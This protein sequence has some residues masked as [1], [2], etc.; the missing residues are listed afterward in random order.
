MVNGYSGFF[1]ETFL[2]LKA[3]MRG[4]PDERSIEAL[5]DRGVS[6][7]VVP[8]FVAERTAVDAAAASSHRLRWRFGDD[9]NGI[10]VYALESTA[11]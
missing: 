8:R 7:V 9:R 6:A 11:P 3:A 2:S 1:P 5:A 4:F 10:D